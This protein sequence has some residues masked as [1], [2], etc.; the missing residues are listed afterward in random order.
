[1]TAFP[2]HRRLLAA[3]ALTVIAAGS[4]H[5]DVVYTQKTKIKGS[6]DMGRMEIVRMGR[7][8]KDMAREESS[9]RFSGAAAR[10][11]GAK[12]V[13]SIEI[14]RL[15]QSSFW[16]LEPTE[17]T[18]TER[19][20]DEVRADLRRI[21]AEADTSTNCVEA[22][23]A[24][25]AITVNPSQQMRMVGV[26]EAKRTTIQTATRV[27][28]LRTGQTR[29]GEVVLDLWMAPGVPGQEE[30][31]AFAAARSNRLALAS[32][33]FPLEGLAGGYERSMQKIR[34]AYDKLPGY[35]V[36]W[37]WT[38]RTDLS[39][40]DRAALAETA[41][42]QEE[43]ADSSQMEEMARP[44]GPLTDPLAQVQTR[45]P[46]AATDKDKL[47]PLEPNAGVFLSLT[48]ADQ[49]VEAESGMTIIFRVESV[50]ESAAETPIDP[51]SFEIPA[52]YTKTAS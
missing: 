49:E 36:E 8:H 9:I 41:K 37:E 51:A 4:V 34:A 23:D 12:P 15:D 46:E 44:E 13:Q 43:G 17:R 26:W 20:L 38:I 11:A 6:G 48:S 7:I 16:S 14:L 19:S 28:D 31:R 27:V 47:R 25:P 3:L 39:A 45:S 35:P 32:E 21:A 10:D 5:A 33:L 50:L 1:M 2:F 22:P 42:L 24:V 30:M 18:F 52:N 40:E 29:N